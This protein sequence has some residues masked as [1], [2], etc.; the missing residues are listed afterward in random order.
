MRFITHRQK[1]LLFLT[2]L[3]FLFFLLRLPSLFEPNW[4]GDEGIY[5]AIGLALNQ[6]RILYSQIWDNKPPLLY[7]L[8]AFLHSDQFTIRL[9]S[10]LIGILSLACF[11]YLSNKLFCN[12]KISVLSTLL[13]AI[14]FGLPTFEGNIANAEN[15][16]LLP[17]IIA[18]Y[19]VY[20]TSQQI[21]KYHTVV[22]WNSIPFQKYQVYYFIAGLFLS[23]AFLF[24]IVAIFDLAAFIS[25]LVSFQL[26]NKLSVSLFKDKKLLLSVGQKILPLLI[27]FLLPILLT[28]FYFI[29]MNVLPDFIQAIFLGNI[30]YVGYGNNFFIPQGILLF[31][32]LFL[33]IFVFILFKNRAVL[34]PAVLFILLWT[35]FSVFNTFF[36]QRPYTHYLLVSLPSFSLL[37]GLIMTKQTTAKKSIFAILFIGITFLFLKS[38]NYFSAQRTIG[39]Y[40]NFLDYIENHKDTFSYQSFFDRNTPRDYNLANFLEHATKK[41]DTLF[42]W[43]DSAQIYPLSHK[44][45]P[46][47]YVVAYHMLHDANTLNIAQRELAQTRPKYIIIQPGS[48]IIPFDMSNYL[49]RYGINGASI[50]ERTL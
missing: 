33:G 45:P 1:D 41:E 49:F 38:F 15:F 9:V 18:A 43:G 39:Y 10:L 14:L 8:Y 5:Q 50:Y 48:Q 6:G 19:F 24:K 31:K 26:L 16:M 40:Q 27:G 25:Y 28:M 36:S 4:Y 23:I 21:T 29:V 17:S 42:V 37:F 44:V 22:R 13:F 11:Y 47:K 30:G 7:I 3:S 12:K 32:L 46:I 34:S 20:V 2:L 35:G